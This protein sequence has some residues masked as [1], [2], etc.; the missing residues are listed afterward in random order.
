WLVV[1]RTLAT[2]SWEESKL[3]W[4]L[5][6]PA[7]LTEVFQFSIGFVTASFVGHIGVVELA[8][9]TVVESI[10]EG[11]A[12]GVLVGTPQQASVR[13]RNLTNNGAC[14]AARQRSSAW[15]ARWTR[16]AGRRW[17]PGSWTCWASTS[18]S[19][20]SSAARP[21]WRSRRRTPSPRRSWAPSS[22]SRPPSRSPR[23][24]TRGGRSRGCSRTP[25]TS[26]CR[27]SSRRR[28]GCGP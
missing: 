1:M 26:R 9:V 22:G 7:V 2:K 27:S 17:A 6:F 28:A 11:F 10:L 13:A 18:N 20:G 8:A 15:G 21:Q 16:C 3:L 19:R 14:D 4:R 23:G 12:Y 25:P 5:A 24:R